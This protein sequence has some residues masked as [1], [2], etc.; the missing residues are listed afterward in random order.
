MV[1]VEHWHSVHPAFSRGHV[2]HCS[3]RVLFL[4]SL[5]CGAVMKAF[6]KDSSKKDKNLNYVC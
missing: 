5:S 6:A 1:V 4:K 2:K 3:G